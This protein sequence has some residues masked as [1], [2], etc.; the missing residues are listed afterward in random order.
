MV[1]L[2]LALAGCGS[3]GSSSA[4]QDALVVPERAVASGTAT[5]PCDAAETAEF[6]SRTAGGGYASLRPPSPMPAPGAMP[7]GST[8]AQIADH[9]Q[10]VVGVDQNTLQFGYRNP[11]TGKLDGF[12]ID[13]LREVARAIFPGE[14]DIDTRIVFKAVTTAER[15]PAVANGDVDVLASLLTVTCERARDVGLSTVYYLAHQRFLVRNGS[16][17]RG[18]ADL[19]GKRVCATAGSTSLANLE[20]RV[21]AAKPYPVEARTD[22]LVALQ[23]GTVDAITSD[24]TILHSFQAQD[25]KTTILPDTLSDEPYAIAVRSDREDLLRFVNGVLDQ[26]RAD[27]TLRGFEMKWNI[28]EPLPE[29]RY[30]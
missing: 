22:C 28:D 6:A 30:R 2:G 24:D 8:M 5:K 17:I 7:A 3:S 9:G 11:L 18:A 15:V 14:T 25:P 4:A 10:L 12:D 16:H 1:V 27:G 21:P 29:P 13:L 23:Q 19:A 20:A 26:M